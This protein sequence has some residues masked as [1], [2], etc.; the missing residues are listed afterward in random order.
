MA[1]SRSFAFGNRIGQ[2]GREKSLGR[3]G[4]LGRGRIDQLVRLAEEGIVS[5]IGFFRWASRGGWRPLHGRISTV[6]SGNPRRP[7]S[8]VRKRSQPCSTEVARLIASTVRKPCWARIEV[9]R[10]RTAA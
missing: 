10:S 5:H 1:R 7:T 9:A 6:I 4:K 2:L 3:V 8:L